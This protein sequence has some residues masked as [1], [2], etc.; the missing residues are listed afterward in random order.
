MSYSAIIKE[1][2]EL[3]TYRKSLRR[4]AGSVTS[5]ILLQ[6]IMHWASVKGDQEFYKFKE[7]CKH[8]AYREG[9]SWIEELGFSANEFDAA[10]KNIG[11]KLKSGQKPSDIVTDPSAPLTEQAKHMVLYWTDIR[12]MTWYF[13]NEEV[14]TRLI[15]L[16]Y[17]EQE[18]DLRKPAKRVYQDPQGRFTS[19]RKTDVVYTETTTEI[20][21]ETTPTR[22][23]DLDHHH[24]ST[25]AQNAESPTAKADDDDGLPQTDIARELALDIAKDVPGWVGFQPFI[26]GL[27]DKSLSAAVGWLWLWQTL[28]YTDPSVD[29]PRDRIA[30]RSRYPC[31]PFADVKSIPGK[32]VTQ[33]RLGNAAPLHEVDARVLAECLAQWADGEVRP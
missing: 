33:V 24:H 27:D 15:N 19:A 9:D 1:D 32:I 22:V 5:T 17:S 28:C 21:S 20:T 4:L 10:L 12:R 13:Y 16:I 7:P 6:Q 14:A 18:V 2:K 26:E 29:D 30:R 23:E 8:E 25:R 3:I 11:T 31:D